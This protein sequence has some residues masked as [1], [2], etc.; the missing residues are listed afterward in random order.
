MIDSLPRCYVGDNNWKR[1]HGWSA[2]SSTTLGQSGAHNL[3]EEGDAESS[4]EKKER[5]IK[6]RGEGREGTGAAAASGV[7]DGD[8]DGDDFFEDDGGTATEAEAEVVWTSE[9]EFCPVCCH[10]VEP[11]EELT[12]LMCAHAFHADCLR[13]WLK[14]HASCPVCRHKVSRVSMWQR[15]G[16]WSLSVANH[17]TRPPP[18]PSSSSQRRGSAG[19][20]INRGGEENSAEEE[21][22]TV[23]EMTPITESRE[24]QR[25]EDGDGDGDGEGEGEGEGD[26]GGDRAAGN[27]DIDMD[28]SRAVDQSRRTEVTLTVHDVTESEL[29]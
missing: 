8:G 17:A 5:N 26:G 7:G 28:T 6:R 3:E 11:G 29:M 10:E 20:V 19:Q 27:D 4:R 24:G 13:P 2:P 25:G 15:A 9:R 16:I 21:M 18:P 12:V 1:L 23:I 14:I 22:S